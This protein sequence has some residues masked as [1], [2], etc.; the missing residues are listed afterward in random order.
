MRLMLA[1]H[2]RF[3]WAGVAMGIAAGLKALAW[4]ALAIA[5]IL[6]WVRGRWQALTPFIGMVALVLVAVLGLPVL[7]DPAAFVVNTIKLPLGVLPVKLTAESPLPGH[8]LS[9]AGPVGHVIVLVLLGIAALTIGVRALRRPPQDAATAARWIA[10]G[11]LVALLLAPATRYGYLVY[12][13]GLLLPVLAP[14]TEHGRSRSRGS[15]D[16]RPVRPM[17]GTVCRHCTT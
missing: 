17:P 6:V 3:E 15:A 10:L 8:L 13:V 5:L 1:S 16:G 4:P 14:D 2:E 9:Q 7:T 12:S 11:M